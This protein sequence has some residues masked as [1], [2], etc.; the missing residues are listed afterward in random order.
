MEIFTHEEV[1][2]HLTKIKTPFGVAVYFAHGSEKGLVIDTGMGIGDLK[3]YIDAMTD[4]PYEVALT[5]GHCDH[6]GGASQFETVYLNPIDFELEK[7]HA[8]LEH[9][10][11]DVF[12][13]PWGHPDFITK[14][15]FVPQRTEPYTPLSEGIVFDLGGEQVSFIALPGHTKGLLVPVL[16]EDRIAII[17][18]GLGENTLMLL[19]ECTSIEEYRESLRHLK[20]FEN[21]FDICLRFHGNGVSQKQIIDDTIEL[22]EEVLA[23]TDAKIPVKRMGRDGR[24]AR[25]QEHPGKEGNFIY[26]PEKIMKA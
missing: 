13:S 15:D 5:H 8:S 9:R 4:L 25:P 14:E 7:T 20:S 26:D 22:C 6:A 24:F 17:G 2:P 16:K 3:G 11:Y 19:E 1:S 18:D 10:L 23:G 12:E 21:M